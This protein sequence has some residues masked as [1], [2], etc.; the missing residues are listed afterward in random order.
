MPKREEIPDATRSRPDPGPGPDERGESVARDLLLL[1]NE[2]PGAALP[3]ALELLAV[4]GNTGDHR[5]AAIAGRAAGLAEA[6][7]GDLTTSVRY[8]DAAITAAGHTGDRELRAET[9]MTAGAVHCWAGDNDIGMQ[10]LEQAIGE[11]TGVKLARA[12]VQRGSIRYR[13]AEFDAA[14]ADF[15]AAEVILDDAGDDMWLAHLLNNRGL[16]LAYKGSLPRAEADIERARDVYAGLGH[17]FSVAQMLHNLGWVAARLGDVPRALERFDAAE[18]R[19]AELGNEP[20]ELFRDRSAALVSVHLVDE[21]Y[22][23]AMRAAT[24]LERDGHAAGRAEALARA[25]EAALLAGRLDAAAARA[26]EAERSFAGQRR[27]GWS[28]Y[29]EMIGLRARANLGDESPRLWQRACHIAAELD[30]AGLESGATAAKVLAA[31]LA[32]LAG[33]IDAARTELAGARPALTRA[34]IDLRAEAWYVAARLRLVAGNRAGAVRAV[35]AGLRAVEQHQAVQGATET[36]A[37]AAGH[38]KRLAALGVD[39]AWQ[40]GRPRRILRWMER[41]RAGA[42]RYPPVRV[43]DDAGLAAE[44]AELRRVEQELRAGDIDA[45]IQL[46]LETQR[47]RLEDRIRRRTRRTQGTD[48]GAASLDLGALLD[49]LGDRMLIEYGRVD[50][51]VAAITIADGKLRRHA[52]AVVSQVTD[53]IDL[54][55]FGLGRVATGRGS[56]ASLDAARAAVEDAAASLSRMLLEPLQIGDR[57]LILVPPPSLHALAWHLLPAATGRPLTVSPSAELW[58]RRRGEVAIAEPVLLAGPRLPEAPA[59]VAAVAAVHGRARRFDPSTGS[60]P[61]VRDALER[62]TLAHLAC[63]GR[64]RAENPLFSALEMADGWF[65]VYDFESL[66]SVPDLMV[67][68]A[69]EAGLSAERPGDEMMGIVAGLLGAGARSVVASVGL[70]PDAA[71][72]REVMTEFHRGLVAG[73]RPS[74]ALAAAQARAIEAGATAAASFVCFGSG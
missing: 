58:L 29:A 18:A 42:L 2:D 37:H 10:L 47:R 16:C 60:V 63:H 34:T 27:I 28:R 72:T 5:V 20:A 44:L 26:D 67:L 4:A 13:A 14:L 1:A 3:R 66:A 24:L 48:A 54:L 39:L 9:E 25:A 61:A 52:G 38:A 35:D 70:V 57:E 51:R 31:D 43:P 19:Y 17:R 21:A 8:L 74:A 46:R 40:S 33:D 71:A 23:S 65:T 30:E 68:S 7:V 73:A 22:A 69:C 12:L 50:G 62:T 49:A 64:F 6:Y 55:R 32:L 56:E 53:A 11:L 45:G 36:R 59:E 15:D 41:T